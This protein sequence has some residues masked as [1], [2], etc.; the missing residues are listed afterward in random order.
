MFLGFL[1]EIKDNAENALNTVKDSDTFRQASTMVSNAAETAQA[2]A[3]EKLGEIKNADSCGKFTDFFGDDAKIFDQAA[4]GLV[5]LSESEWKRVSELDIDDLFG[6][7]NFTADDVCAW[8]K[9]GLRERN[10]KYT[11]R[12]VSDL[13]WDEVLG[14]LDATKLKAGYQCILFLR[15]GIMWAIDTREPEFIDYTTLASASFFFRRWG[16]GFH[17]PGSRRCLCVPCH[18]ENGAGGT[19]IFP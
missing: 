5:A 17:Q 8:G 19:D 15:K 1:K 2:L 4:D 12:D 16:D 13:D 3:A 7:M 18:P 6:T 9:G 11:F 14:Y 10:V